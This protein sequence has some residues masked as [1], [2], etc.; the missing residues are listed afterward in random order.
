[1]GPTVHGVGQRRGWYRLP[2][3]LRS[4]LVSLPSGVLVVAAFAPSII[5]NQESWTAQERA[6]ANFALLACAA[7]VWL[8]LWSVDSGRERR[9]DELKRQTA[10]L[11]P[12]SALAHVTVALFGEDGWRLTLMEVSNSGTDVDVEQLET[13]HSLASRPQW[14]SAGPTR[15]AL[16]GGVFKQM[17]AQTARVPLVHQFSGPFETKAE[18]DAEQETNRAAWTEAVF[19]GPGA[20]EQG[21]SLMPTHVYAMYY[22]RA[23]EGY[24]EWAVLLESTRADGIDGAFLGSA[25]TREWVRRWIDLLA[26]SAT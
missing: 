14:E 13:R 7:T 9:I 22:M 6:N 15:L 19:G 18:V 24:G 12:R 1:M 5:D 4:L 21:D 10:L 8:V 2:P 26:A 11:D 23:G 17:F 20:L 25:G 16:S 3:W